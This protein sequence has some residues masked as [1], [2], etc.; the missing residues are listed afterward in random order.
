MLRISPSYTPAPDLECHRLLISESQPLL[1]PF[2]LI[3]PAEYLIDI[4]VSII[5]RLP[6]F[7]N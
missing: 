7:F 3:A 5:E 4:P 6:L 2:F 1:F